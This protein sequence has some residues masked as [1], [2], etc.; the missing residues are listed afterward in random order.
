MITKKTADLPA[1]ILTL[2]DRRQ[3]LRNQGKFTEADILRDELADHGYL[4]QDNPD[5]IK[6]LRRGQSASSAGNYLVLFGSGE[7]SPT[8]RRIHESVFQAIG[9][10]G[11]SIAIISTPAGFQPN[12]QAVYEDIAQF[13]HERLQNFHPHISI[14][15]AN[16]HDDANNPDLIAPIRTADYIFTGPGSPS[17]A[18]KHL[19]DTL[20]LQSI[21]DR[22]QKN[23][24]LCLAS[25]AAIA[26]SRF[27]LPVYEIYKVG[28]PLR[29]LPGLNIFS[30][31]YRPLTIIPHLNNAEGG[32]KTDTSYCFMGRERFKKLQ[33]MLPA[34]ETVWGID[35]QTAVIINLKTNKVTVQGK[36]SHRLIT[37]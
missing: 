9:K 18:V 36:G 32:T 17:Y 35:E 22:L 1:D 21:I 25:A 20:L 3:T 31:L 34:K 37:P 33:S 10:N 28:E 24:S 5:G 30:R 27:V 8:G 14:I 11:L 29:W 2:L 15:Y 26:F 19:Q 12:V 6:I 4:I 7:I 16:T 23:A 13:F